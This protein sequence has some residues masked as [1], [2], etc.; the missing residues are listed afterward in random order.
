M[1]SIMK[2]LFDE[3]PKNFNDSL[4]TGRGTNLIRK[5]NR[6]RCSKDKWPC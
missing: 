4:E 3:K 2:L 5:T 1:S 6:V